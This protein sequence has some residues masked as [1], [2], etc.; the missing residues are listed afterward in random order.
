VR[1]WEL[2]RWHG[3]PYFYEKDWER[4]EFTPSLRNRS[5]EEVL[6]PDEYGL[7]T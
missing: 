4:K 3:V 7:G 1:A 5:Y 6:F 2:G